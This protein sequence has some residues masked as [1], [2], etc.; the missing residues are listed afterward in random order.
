MSAR[1]PRTI[2]VQVDAADYAELHRLK[3]MERFVAQVFDEWVSGCAD[4][5][6]LYGD[7]LG[8]DEVLACAVEEIR[9]A[10]LAVPPPCDC[11]SY[12]LDDNVDSNEVVLPRPDWMHEGERINGVP[13]DACIAD[14]V[15]HL[16]DAGVKTWGSCCGHNGRFG[17]PSLLLDRG[18][19]IKAVRELIGQVDARRWCLDTVRPA[20]VDR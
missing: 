19:D 10:R 2:K 4:L 18:E 11:A 1:T 15:R 20:G 9:S 3:A 16:W 5:M 7:G 6:A 13:V 17:P 12:N 14:V 8:W